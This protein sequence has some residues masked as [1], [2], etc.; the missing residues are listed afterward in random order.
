MGKEKGYLSA[1]HLSNFIEESNNYLK[2][3][4]LQHGM[5]NYLNFHQYRNNW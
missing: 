2:T 5:S 3:I 4:R 1:Y